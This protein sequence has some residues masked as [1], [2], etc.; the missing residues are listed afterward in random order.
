MTRSLF[1]LLPPSEAK[2]SGGVRTSKI[3]AFDEEL[4]GARGDVLVGLA[5]VLQGTSSERVSRTLNARGALLERS[6]ASTRELVE[7]IAPVLPAWRRYS[8]VV[9]LHLDPATLSPAQRR[10]V[11]V[12]SGLYGVTRGDDP[13]ADYRLKMNVSL[14]GVGNVARFWRS[15]LGAPLRRRLEGARVVNLLAN[16]HQAAIDLDSLK[17]SCDVITITFVAQRG[18]RL[19]GHD[20]KAV[21]G[22]VARE[23]LRG[24]LA[25]MDSFEWQGWRSRSLEGGLCIEAPRA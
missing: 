19:V 12:P 4:A 22:I 24:G 6:L 21:K 11:L 23:L 3:G 20:A 15:N 10:R 7:G 17:T 18:G 16:E 9:W 13:I 5:Q 1:V 8:G 14:P 25:S 2:L